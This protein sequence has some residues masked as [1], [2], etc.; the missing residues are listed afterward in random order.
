[1]LTLYNK[2]Y[3]DVAPEHFKSAPINAKGF[4]ETL[5]TLQLYVEDCTSCNLCV[6]VCPA[7]SP[8][9]P[10]KKAINM[11]EKQ[12]ILE[13]ERENI[14]YFEA[15][16]WNDRSKIDFSLVRG[17]QYLEP[18]FEFSGACAGCGETPYINP[19]HLGRSTKMAMAPHGLILCLKT[20]Q[21]SA[22]G[23]G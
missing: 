5:Y 7:I 20:M 9:D 4:P 11:G 10:N 15:I 14:A 3:K 22:W 8:T 2:K 21:N 23:C 18:L 13:S 12:S 19:L 1:M 6:E 17:A 16:P